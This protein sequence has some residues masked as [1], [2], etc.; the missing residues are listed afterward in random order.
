MLHAVS[1]S[2]PAPPVN[3]TRVLSVRSCRT[4]RALP[5][6]RASRTEISLL[7]DAP[8][9][10]SKFAT[11]APAMISTR[12]TTP[13]TTATIGAASSRTPGSFP[14]WVNVKTDSARIW[15]EAWAMRGDMTSRPLSARSKPTSSPRRPTSRSQPIPRWFSRSVVPVLRRAPADAGRISCCIIEG[16]QNWL[17]RAIAALL[18]PGGA[19]PITVNGI[20]LT[21]TVRPAMPGSDPNR[22]THN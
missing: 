16:T 22:S 6:P 4:R 1:R 15:G 14:S 13:M 20:E 9:D 7:R 2:P 18:K 5:A 3:A 19:T 21:V 8:W 11:F 17:V 12:M 10:K